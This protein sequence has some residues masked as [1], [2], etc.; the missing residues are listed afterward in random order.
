MSGQP[1]VGDEL[2]VLAL[3]VGRGAEGVEVV[4][5]PAG[6]ALLDVEPGQAQQPA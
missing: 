2:L 5:Q 1:V 3:P 4:E 6:L